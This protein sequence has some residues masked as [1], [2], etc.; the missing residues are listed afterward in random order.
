MTRRAIA[1]FVLL[2]TGVSWAMQLVAIGV[3]G[4]GTG[5]A[6]MIFLAIMWS[7]SLVAAGFLILHPP[8]RTGVLWRLGRLRYLPVGIAVETAL[9]FAVVG[10]LVATGLAISGWFA[11]GADGVAIS[12]GPWLL[13]RGQQNWALFGLNVVVTAV[14]FS[15]MNLVAATGE[16]FGWRGFLQGHLV[17][18]FG[19][20]PGIL[21]LAAIWAVW[22]LPALLAGYNFPEHPYLG[23]LVL[24]PLQM[25]GASLFFGWLTIRSGSFWPAALGHGAVNSIQQGVVGNLGPA[26]SALHADLLLTALMVGVGLICWFALGSSGGRAPSTGRR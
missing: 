23:A 18:Q 17:T 10:T 26:G 7:P 2:A 22:H 1:L 5:P 19:V 21:I 16:E 4:L 8:S 13:G 9:G 3:F 20:R 15:I 6:A 14:A 25:I 12:G 11:F 24:F